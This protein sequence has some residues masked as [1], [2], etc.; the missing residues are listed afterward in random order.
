MTPASTRTPTTAHTTHR[1]RDRCFGAGRIRRQPWPVVAHRCGTEVRR[2]RRPRRRRGAGGHGGTGRRDRPPPGPVRRCVGRGRVLVVGHSG[3]V[4][5][6]TEPDDGVGHRTAAR[7]GAGRPHRGHAHGPGR[8]VRSGGHRALDRARRA[9]APGRRWPT[10]TCPSRLA[11]GDPSVR[12]RAAELAATQPGVTLVPALLDDPDP[13]VVE[14]AAWATGEREEVGGRRP[15][16]PPG[17]GRRPDTPT[18]CAGRPRSPPSGPSA[19][20]PACRPCWPPSTTSRPSGAGPRW[21]SPPS[22]GPR[23]RPR[24]AGASTTADWQVRQVA[25]D[26]LAVD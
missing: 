19:T 17:H 4:Q 23:S 8:P 25:E 26:L 6:A 13:S 14:M 20:R 21:P 10:T 2:W 9:R 7:R 22:R 1:T 15:A 16:R 24:S 5:P 18:R 11:D 3:A 12:R